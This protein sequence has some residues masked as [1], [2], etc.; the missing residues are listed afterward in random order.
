M[1]QC[2]TEDSQERPTFSRLV[3]GLSAKLTE[4]ANYLDLNEIDATVA[5][6]GDDLEENPTQ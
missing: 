6:R 1:V 5:P 3:L 4:M 2:W